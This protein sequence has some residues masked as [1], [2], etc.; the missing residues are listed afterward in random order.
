MERGLIKILMACL[1]FSS[2]SSVQASV[3]ELTQTLL[4]T[5]EEKAATET[6]SVDSLAPYYLVYGFEVSKSAG[7]GDVLGVEGAFGA[8]FHFKK[9]EKP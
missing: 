6:R 8:E 4:A 1:I 7:L 2:T 3:F 5:A 9:V